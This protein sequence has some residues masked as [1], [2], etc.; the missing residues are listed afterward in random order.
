MAPIGLWTDE[1]VRRRL[2]C[3]VLLV[4]WF[5][6]GSWEVEGRRRESKRRRDRRGARKR[7]A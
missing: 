6:L 2:Y 7:K 5:V 4:E 3:L 1:R